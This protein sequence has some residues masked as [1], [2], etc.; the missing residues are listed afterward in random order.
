[1]WPERQQLFTCSADASIK[2]WDCATWQE[3]TTISVQDAHPPSSTG[4]LGGMTTT[5]SGSS[6]GGIGST[7]NNS[8]HSFAG[9]FRP[10]PKV[11]IGMVRGWNRRTLKRLRSS[12]TGNATLFSG[13]ADG[14][15][16]TA[17]GHIE[18]PVRGRG[19]GR[20]RARVTR[21]KTFAVGSV[22]ILASASVDLR[23]FGLGLGHV[24]VRKV[25]AAEDNGHTDA[26]MD[27]EFWV[28][29]NETFSISGGL[30]A[31]IIVW[32]LTPLFY[33]CLKKRRTRRMARSLWEELPSFAYKTTLGAD[34]NQGH[35][36]AVRALPPV[37]AI[38]S[39]PLA[40]I[41]R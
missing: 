41:K 39:S 7:H 35:H 16:R 30:D 8:R 20:P 22:P 24:P 9:C 2:P 1:M 32:G 12:S 27:L 13:G 3:V 36:D 34:L 26:V 10:N 17:D 11:S 19:H 31:E 28:N 29:Q 14:R 38:R 37:Q 40:T 4:I 23:R 25:L 18:Q 15:I 21:L 33:S 6:S 5:T